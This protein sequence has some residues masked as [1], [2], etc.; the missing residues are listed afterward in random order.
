[1]KHNVLLVCSLSSPDSVGSLS[2][3]T[4]PVT[5]ALR[6]ELLNQHRSCSEGSVNAIHAYHVDDDFP[7]SDTA[8]LC[9]RVSPDT[10]I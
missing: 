7:E 6:L 9:V 4:L 2:L 8:V 10:V 1:M 5:S 3:G